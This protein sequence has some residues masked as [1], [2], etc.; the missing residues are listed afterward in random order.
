[1][2][3]DSSGNYTLPS[4]NP[5]VTLTTI[6][7]SWANQTLA[8][9]ASEVTNSLDRQGRGAMLA[10]LKVYS[11]SLLAPGLSWDSEAGS[12]WYRAA[13]GDFRFGVAGALVA[14]ASALGLLQG[15]GAGVTYP[16]GYKDIPQNIQSAAYTLV[17]SDAGKHVLHP[18]AD[19]TARVFTIPANASVPFRIGTAVTFVNQN[20]AGSVTIAITTDTLRLAGAGTTGS[21]TLA[22]NGI[23]T[24]LKVTATEWLISGTGLT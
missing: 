1:M 16:A 24:A 10:P 2:A 6:A 13:A 7:S 14:G 17:A 15:D 5:V 23:C 19:V 3:R 4:S 8:D 21:R 11:G 18:T 9:L 22:A 20:G 12:G